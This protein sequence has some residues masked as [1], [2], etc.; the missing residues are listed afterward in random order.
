M[1]STRWWLV[2]VAVGALCGAGCSAR[3]QHGLDERQANELQALLVE[4]GFAARKVAEGGKKP[5]FAIEL[6]EDQ[7]T[8]A[9]RV[10]AELGLPRQKSLTS[11][12]LIAGGAL[13][14]TPAMERLKTVIGLQGD[15]ERT[16]ETLDGVTS[17]S[18]HLVMPLASRPG[19]PGGAAKASALLRVRPG[20]AGRVNSLR[21]QLRTLI[22]GAVDGL[23]PDGVILVVTEAQTSVSSP[24]VRTEPEARLRWIVAGLGA[25]VAALAAAIVWFALRLRKAVRA[26]VRQGTALRSTSSGGLRKA[27]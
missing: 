2:A 8:D 11:P 24:R 6:A 1:L 3:V 27:A 7:A 17:A 26:P 13:V 19:Q 20:H 25:G 10:L 22:A 14:E 18:V 12:E 23:S 15:L 16:L 9:V 5:T 4:R 21:E